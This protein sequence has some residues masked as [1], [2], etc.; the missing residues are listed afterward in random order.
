MVNAESKSVELVLVAGG[1]YQERE[2]WIASA[3]AQHNAV[4]QTI[5]QSKI[6][7]ILEGLPSGMMP[8]QSSPTLFIERIAPGCFCCIGNL[9]LRVTLMR[10]LRIKPHYLYLAMN[11]REH[12]SNLKEFLQQETFA[13]L[14]HFGQEI[15]L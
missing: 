13:G 4:V 12:L 5:P 10:L 3:V 9:V 11:D 6:G 15:K 1:N 2:S 7:I 8:L 14:L